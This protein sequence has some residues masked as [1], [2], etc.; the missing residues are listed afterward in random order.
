MA[1]TSGSAL[2]LRSAVAWEVD[3]HVH[4]AMFLPFR[5]QRL[6]STTH[7]PQP[8][9]ALC[10]KALELSIFDVSTFTL[11]L[12]DNPNMGMLCSVMYITYS[13]VR[14]N[15][16]THFGMCKRKLS[17]NKGYISPAA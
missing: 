4:N 1:L 6:A 8:A 11:I 9:P 7:P 3:L 5:K 15:S 16:P 2:T 13:G 10:Q 14:K 12:L 17:E